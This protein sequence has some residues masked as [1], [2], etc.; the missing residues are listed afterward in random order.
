MEK[1]FK[2]ASSSSVLLNSISHTYTLN[3]DLQASLCEGC[4]WPPC[5]LNP[6]CGQ[7]PNKAF[8]CRAEPPKLGSHGKTTVWG[9]AWCNTVFYYPPLCISLCE[10]VLS[11]P[12]PGGGHL[13]NIRDTNHL[14]DRRRLNLHNT[15]HWN[16]PYLPLFSLT[17]LLYH[18]LPP[19]EAEI[20]LSCH[21]LT[22]YCFVRRAQKPPDL[23]RSL[24]SDFFSVKAAICVSNKPFLLLIYLSSV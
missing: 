6:Q 1:A 22:I 9:K 17:D 11:F 14:G 10:G 3:S 8:Y 16:N 23:T 19:P 7:T 12:L 13:L 21:F 2:S 24:G 4:M 15:S 20:S 5:T 18:N